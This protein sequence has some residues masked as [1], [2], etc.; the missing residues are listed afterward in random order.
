MTTRIAIVGR[1]NVGK[2]TLFNR[3][4]GRKLAIVDDLPGVTRDRREADARLGPLKFVAIDTAGLEDVRDESLEAR[5]RA[6]TE[7]AVDDAD[8]ILMVIDGRAGV[9][10]MDRHFAGWLHQRRGQREAGWRLAAGEAY[11][12]ACDPVAVSAR[13]REGITNLRCHHLGARQRESPKKADA[14]RRRD[15]PD[16]SIS[17]AFV[18][19]PTSASRRWP[20]ADRRGPD[21][22]RPRGH[23]PRRRGDGLGYRGR[24]AGRHRRPAPPR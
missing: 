11:G 8:V 12:W 7:Q 3:L 1:P 9:T 2:S 6:Q 23:H 14:G 17:I 22:D 16:L 10:P 4:A 19:A 5:M 15:R 24:Q 13:R 21:A 18:A 20:I